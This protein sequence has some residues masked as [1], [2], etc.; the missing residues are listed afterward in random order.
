MTP[1]V[2]VRLSIRGKRSKTEIHKGTETSLLG[3]SFTPVLYSSTPSTM[4]ATHSIILALFCY[5]TE[6]VSTLPAFQFPDLPK[7]GQTPPLREGASS[8]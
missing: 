7:K 8:A 5:I 3:N 4:W 2:V 1:L 6:S